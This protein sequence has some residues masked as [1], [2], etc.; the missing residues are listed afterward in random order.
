MAVDE[1]N[2][3]TAQL[4]EALRRDRELLDRIFETVPLMMTIY[5]PTTRVLRVNR[6]FERLIGWSSA[7][8]SAVSL[9]EQVYPDPEYREQAREYMQACR[10]E[11]RD[12]RVT[13][14]DG[15]M[16]ESSWTN[17]RLSDDTQ[18][19]IGVDVTERQRAEAALRASEEALLGSHRLKDEFLAVLAHE[20]RNP[21]SPMRN[22]MELLRRDGV[23]R[24]VSDRA[25]AI[26][27][28]QLG[29]M[30]RLVDDLLDISRIN[31]GK[32]DLRRTE[33]DLDAVIKKAVES[34]EPMLK[35][36]ELSIVF[37]SSSEPPAIVYGDPV[38]LEQVFANLLHNAA[39]FTPA[40]GAVF[41]SVERSWGHVI[42]RVRDTGIG[43]ASHVLPRVFELFVQG[44]RG[45]DRVHGGLGVGLSL[46]K[47]L[48]DLHGGR[49]EAFSGGVGHGSE[50][51]IRLPLHAW[52][53][54]DRATPVEGE[55]G[56]RARGPESAAPATK[57]VL[58]V[59]D[60][61][62]A[63]SSLAEL[64]AASGY[65]VLVAYDGPS[66]IEQ[67]KKQMV[68]AIVMDLGMP[69][70][71]GYSAARLMRAD[72]SFA[73]VQLIALT[74]WDQEDARRSSAQS[75]FDHHLVKPVDLPVLE[76]L[77]ARAR[78]RRA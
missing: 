21:L 16:I 24:A 10:P 39:K 4:E 28:R 33:V 74:G 77:L 20:L 41:L 42:V 13:T 22:A 73:G 40:R 65:D 6:A 32:V 76:R 57:S 68:D 1:I 36:K 49:V 51:V 70:M 12:F 48:V 26:L 19:G 34:S 75:G 18:L 56:P 43:I 25:L 3:R 35:E 37:E 38:R 53:T 31:T 30:V 2:A 55:L 59:D 62:D 47:R 78:Q 67:G 72:P 5:D 14:R 29:V 9:M 27:D 64:L 46:V 66:A 15:R 52:A 45:V 63:A 23:S 44:D 50:F 71:S 8:L 61:V 7:E 54:G 60:N 17:I 58:V 69:G 11:W